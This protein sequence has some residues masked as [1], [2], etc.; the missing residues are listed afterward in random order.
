MAWVITDQAQL[1]YNGLRNSV[2]ATHFPNADHLLTQMNSH[3]R[4]TNLLLCSRRLIK[5]SL[6]GIFV[7]QARISLL[8]DNISKTRRMELYVMTRK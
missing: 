8:L 6:G 3:V 2:A 4:W 1:L 5:L 7:G